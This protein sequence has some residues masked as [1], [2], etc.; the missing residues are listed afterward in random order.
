MTSCKSVPKWQLRGAFGA[1]HPC[2]SIVLVHGA[3][4]AV[5]QDISG[6]E[7]WAAAL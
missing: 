5:C 1:L 7:G 2:H 6:E 3:C 4:P